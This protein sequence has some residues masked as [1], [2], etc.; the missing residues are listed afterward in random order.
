MRVIDVAPPASGF[1]LVLHG[2]AGGR[3]SVLTVEEERLYSAGLAGAYRAGQV[4]LATGGSA[5]DAV[6]A[7]VKELENCVLFN[8]GRG[9][10]LTAR[11]EAELDASVMTGD[12]RAG[13]VAVTRHAKNP[14][15]AA[16]KVLEE[17]AHVL[18]VAPGETLLSEWGLEIEES[19]YFVTDSR[20][21][22][23]AKVQAKEL[24]QSR[25][26][27]VGAVAV[28]KHGHVASATS[29]GGMVNQHEGRV[30]DTPVIG[31]GS[32]ARDGV[33]AVSCTGEGEAFIQGVVAH[34]VYARMH[35]AG[36]ALP[37]A[38]RGTIEAELNG[39]DA[40]GGLIAVGADGRVVVA[41]NSSA[42]FAAYEESGELVT[43]T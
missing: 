35:Y 9:A 13:A 15:F 37:D 23:L 27:T 20:R 12:G 22:Q 28:D 8:A 6:C 38:V 25:H 1:A 32:Y 18:L 14:I 41:Y 19:S 33:V 43:L 42:M 36:A 39:R 10:A 34:D 26:G 16:R 40:D 11:G 29:T 31:A 5:L 3:D 30:G 17:T 2:G 21:Q 7:T 4:V 24:A